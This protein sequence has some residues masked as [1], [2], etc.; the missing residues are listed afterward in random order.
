MSVLVAIQSSFVYRFSEVVTDDAFKKYISEAIE[1]VRKAGHWDEKQVPST[2]INRKGETVSTTAYLGRLLVKFRMS[3]QAAAGAVFDPALQGLAPAAY[4]ED[5]QRQLKPV[6][7]A[8]DG[9]VWISEECPAGKR[10]GEEL[11][12][13]PGRGVMIGDNIAL[14]QVGADWVKG[15][16]LR[17]E[18]VPGHVET[19]K[20]RYGAPTLSAE[21]KHELG[22][23]K[24]EEIGEERGREEAVGSEDARIL[25][26]DYDAQE[27]RHKEWMT[28]LPS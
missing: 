20:Q 9:M 8:P 17:V 2:M 21:L 10:L 26:V 13:R 6:V 4:D 14:V 23:G 15:S 5:L 16:L 22:V 11:D 3:R 18:V 1:E 24:A 19:L 27:E 7:S 12:V 28:L 25:Q